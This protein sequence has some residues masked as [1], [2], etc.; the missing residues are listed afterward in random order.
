MFH[1]IGAGV[2]LIGRILFFVIGQNV[3]MNTRDADEHHDDNDPRNALY[4]W[5]HCCRFGFADVDFNKTESRGI[6]LTEC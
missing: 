2:L 1:E 5:T 3:T 4:E 6:R